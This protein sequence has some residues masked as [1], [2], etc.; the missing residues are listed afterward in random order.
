MYALEA[1]EKRVGTEDPGRVAAGE[2][3]PERPR[4]PGAARPRG[5]KLA[6][7]PAAGS[8]EGPGSRSGERGV[9]K[10]EAEEPAKM[11]SPPLT[12]PS[13]V[14]GSAPAAS[15]ACGSPVGSTARLIPPSLRLPRRG[16]PPLS[17]TPR[18]AYTPTCAARRLFPSGPR[19]RDAFRGAVGCVRGARSLPTKRRRRAPR[20]RARSEGSGARSSAHRRAARRCRRRRRSVAQRSRRSRS[21]SGSRRSS[22]TWRACPAP[23]PSPGSCRRRP[24][25]GAA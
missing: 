16:A 9:R 22:G 18:A 10:D 24:G 21:S 14:T 25:R 23:A 12:S 13:L 5:I 19:E 6:A 17:E 4:L 7:R 8:A 11:T 2:P 1:I 20:E 3:V 15:P